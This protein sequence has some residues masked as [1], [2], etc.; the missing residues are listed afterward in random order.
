MSIRECDVITHLRFKQSMTP[1]NCNAVLKDGKRLEVLL[2]NNTPVVEIENQFFEASAIVNFDRF[3]LKQVAAPIPVPP[4][5]QLADEQI[6]KDET[7]DTSGQRLRMQLQRNPDV[8]YKRNILRQVFGNLEVREYLGVGQSDSLNRYW[9]CR[10]KVTG[11]YVIATQADLTVG[12]V[13][14][15]K[16]AKKPTQQ[17]VNRG[18]QL[19]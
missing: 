16:N 9:N 12:E 5:V 3:E 8:I 19:S 18:A 10:C 2:H 7:A 13:T 4:T 11:K 1:S 17:I 15:C 14:C 6:I